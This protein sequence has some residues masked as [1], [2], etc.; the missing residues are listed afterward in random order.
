M[1]FKKG[2]LPFGKSMS[3]TTQ[4]ELVCTLFF[5]FVGVAAFAAMQFAGGSDWKVTIP[6]ITAVALR[7]VFVVWHARREMHQISALR[8]PKL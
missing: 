6:G 5:A 3:E 4:E 1:T 8:L 2:R 7:T